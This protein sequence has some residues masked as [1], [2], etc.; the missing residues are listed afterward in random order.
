MY[1]KKWFDK[2]EF[3]LAKY[4]FDVL[5]KEYMSIDSFFSCSFVMTQKYQLNEVVS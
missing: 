4:Y 2:T 3:L 1:S 5:G